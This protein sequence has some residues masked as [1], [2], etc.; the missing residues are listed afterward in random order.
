MI[1]LSFSFGSSQSLEVCLDKDARHVTDASF[2]SL[3]LYVLLGRQWVLTEFA[4]WHRRNQSKCEKNPI[5]C[6]IKKKPI[7]HRQPANI[8][9]Y[10][11]KQLLKMHLRW[12]LN[13][14]QW[15]FFLSNLIFI[16]PNPTDFLRVSCNLWMTQMIFVHLMNSNA[17]NHYK[18]FC[19]TK[20]IC[21]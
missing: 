3:V 16:F 14:R 18:L 9:H 13:K 2:P 19:E 5:G 4:G 10:T 12:K 11:L 21:W 8:I 20:G 17:I 1:V 7:T 15:Y 6:P